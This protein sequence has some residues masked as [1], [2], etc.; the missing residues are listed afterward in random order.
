MLT[1][2]LSILVHVCL[3]KFEWSIK[4][5]VGLFALSLLSDSLTKLKFSEFLLIEFSNLSVGSP[6]TVGLILFAYF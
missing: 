3:R 6:Y 1:L 2:L 5:K 4:F